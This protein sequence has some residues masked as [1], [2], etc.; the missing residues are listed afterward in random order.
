MAGGTWT[1]QNQVRP[2][3]YTNIVS[4]PPPLGVAGSR[5]VVTMSI[6]LPW[7][8]SKQV[9]IVRAGDDIATVLG[10]DMTAPTLLLVREALKRAQ[11]LLL[12]RLNTGAKA[13]AAVGAL[14]VTAQHGGTR[15]NDLAVKVQA[16]VDDENLFDVATLLAG[17]EV[18]RQTVAAIANLTPNAWVTF[19]GAGAITETAGSPLA[20]G[21]DGAVT[22]GDHADYLAAIETH[23]FN[24]IA[25]P[26][27]DA[28]LKAL[29][30]AY[31]RRLREE[32]GK[33]IQVVLADYPAA[34]Y[35]GVI[36][37]RNGVILA[38]G[39]TLT[40]AQATAWVAGA[41]AG[42][43]MNQSLTYQAVD[44]AVDAAPRLTHTQTVAALRAGE[45]VFTLNAGRA[46]VEQ[47]INTLTTF[48]PEKAT[49]FSKNRVVR[50]LDGLANDLKGIFE[51][52]YLGK[53]GNNP[54]GRNLLRDEINTH[55]AGLQGAGAIQNYDPQADVT[56]QPG[57]ATDSV[58]VEVYV[59]PVDAIEKIYMRV[60]V[61]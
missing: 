18:D 31:A 14:T 16:N 1:Q 15:G 44:G 57:Q 27:E 25:L 41:T 22:N 56:V 8:P 59:Q 60:E 46:V 45:L 34:D 32:E 40:A 29:Y 50:V 20:G 39:T 7:G 42:A 53:V 5:G 4:A 33:K 10:F 30:V 26:S 38:D 43:A 55:L 9:L 28:A 54:D 3:V 17:R 48:T 2:G 36:S 13:T 11:T 21:T 52:F 47:D 23:E 19:G 58:Y 12:Y 49:H 35:E 51:A 37:V 24:T 61:S 6:P